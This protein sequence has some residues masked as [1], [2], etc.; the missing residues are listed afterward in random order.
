M[1]IGLMA[2]I[3]VF[4]GYLL[5]PPK[6]VRESAKV[7]K[8]IPAEQ[9]CYSGI[10]GKTA[11]EILKINNAVETQNSSFGEF[12]TSLNGKKADSTKEFW[13]F[14]VNGK[15]ASEGAGTYKTKDADVIVWKIDPITN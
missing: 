12:V 1:L 13:G 8:N 9:I 15:M 6:E 2:V 14:Y 5:F 11:L 7:C 4:G 3:L 10:E